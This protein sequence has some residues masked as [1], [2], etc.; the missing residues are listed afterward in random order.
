ME[1]KIFHPNC[2]SFFRKYFRI[3]IKI[4][5]NLTFKIKIN[6]KNDGHFGH[7]KIYSKKAYIFGWNVF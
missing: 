2:K 6:M 1:R 3:K 4:K 7:L 5:V